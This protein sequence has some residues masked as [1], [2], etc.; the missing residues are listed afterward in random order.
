LEFERSSGAHQP[1]GWPPSFTD[2]VE[3]EKRDVREVGESSG[4]TPE[5]VTEVTLGEA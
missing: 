5:L 3:E 1:P 2:D 4:E